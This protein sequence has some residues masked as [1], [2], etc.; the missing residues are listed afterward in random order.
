MVTQYKA[1]FQ[2]SVLQ[3]N[4]TEGQ[5]ARLRLHQ[6][7]P[8]RTPVSCNTLIKNKDNKRRNEAHRGVL[9]REA[10]N[11]CPCEFA[12]KSVITL[13]MVR[14]YGILMYNILTGNDNASSG[15]K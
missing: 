11:H 15:F 9:L 6:S 10:L 14:M 3:L 2:A 4:F 13:S 5:P 1:S 12:C 7:F 8:T